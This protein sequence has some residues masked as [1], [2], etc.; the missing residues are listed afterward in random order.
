MPRPSPHPVGA[1]WRAVGSDGSVAEIWLAARH[2]GTGFEMWRWSF[3][4]KD[5]AY[6]KGDWAPTLRK[7]REECSYKVK[8]NARFRRV[9]PVEEE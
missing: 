2:E 8:G 6:G 9:E 3:R 7:C 5:E 1:R 4:Y